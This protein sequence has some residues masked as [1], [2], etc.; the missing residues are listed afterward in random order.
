MDV[1]TWGAW[2]QQASYGSVL[3]KLTLGTQ[4]F[5]FYLSSK[6]YKSYNLYKLFK[7]YKS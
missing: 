3:N 2:E 7:L 4:F 6:L 1:L 5:N